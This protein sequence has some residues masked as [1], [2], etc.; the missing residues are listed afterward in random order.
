[1]QGDMGGK[2]ARP[3]VLSKSESLMTARLEQCVD[4]CQ[5]VHRLCL[6]L[7]T[8]QIQNGS[9]NAEPDS[10]NRLIDCAEICQTTGSFVSR[11]SELHPTV[12]RACADICLRCADYCERFQDDERAQICAAACRRCAESCLTIEE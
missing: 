7:V 11:N 1:M 5:E 4:N 8:S 9:V 10:L 6:S 12:R 2:P 3:M